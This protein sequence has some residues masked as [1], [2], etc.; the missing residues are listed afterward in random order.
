MPEYP[1]YPLTPSDPEIRQ[2]R[3]NV[4]LVWLVPIAAALVGISMLVHSAVSAGPRIMVSFLTADG[5]EA[6]KTVVKYK[7]VVIG[8]VTAISF[9]TDRSHIE[10]TIELDQ[11]A[12]P[13]TSQDSR[14]WVV[15]PR[16]GAAGVSGVDTLLSGAFIGAD[17]GYSHALVNRFE[18]LEN[19]PPVNFGEKGKRFTLHTTSLGS[20]DIGSPVYYRRLQVG[21]VVAYRMAE[22]GKSVDVDLF[23]RAPNDKFVTSD[24]RFWNASGIDV[25][26]GAGGLKVNTESLS[27][28]ISGGVAFVEPARTDAAP[29]ADENAIFTLFPDRDTALAPA[30]G[31]ARA[32]HMSF[33]QN[34]KGLEVGAPVEFLGVTLGRVTAVALDFDP[35]HQTFPTQVDAVIYPDRMGQAKD[36]LM[37]TIGGKPNDAAVARLMAGFIRN[38]LRAQAKSANLLTGQLYISL[39]FV[40][41]APPMT[42]DTA[43]Q[44]LVIPTVPGS[45]DKL[46]EQLQEFANKL[47]KLPIDQI[48]ASLNGSLGELQKTLK[49]VNGDVLPQMHE[50]LAQAQKTIAG[51][52]DTFAEDSPQRQQLGQAMDEVQRTARSVRVLTD[53]LARHPEAL[54]RGRVQENQPG[55]LHID[56]P[57]PPSSAEET[58]P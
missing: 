50:T 23:I 5:L 2:S 14:F 47:S 25:S 17:A 57:S 35:A 12:K 26:L 3:F 43:A 34:L 58:Q 28:I 32:I 45:L 22:D 31:E 56:Q 1:N 40:K 41:D 20:L 39:G 46:Q 55:A 7:N 54:I 21:Q 51:A 10:A 38:G 24:T 27:S 19:P 48:A 36:K 49:Q 18:G 53:F 9:S 11:S 15:R 33:D 29:A 8:K 13:F 6:N 16:I 4:S 30:D 44:P 37:Q 52:N 42:V